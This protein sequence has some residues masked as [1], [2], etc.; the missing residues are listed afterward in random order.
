MAYA[1]RW[2][3]RA[4]ARNYYIIQLESAKLGPDLT[5]AQVRAQWEFQTLY[6]NLVLI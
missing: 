1:R 2:P 4:R 6:S 5:E 3:N